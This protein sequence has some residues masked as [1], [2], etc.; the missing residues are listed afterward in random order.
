[1]RVVCVRARILVCV[2][3]FIVYCSPGGASARENRSLKNTLFWGTAKFCGFVIAK[4]IGAP[5]LCTGWEG[6]EGSVTQL[7]FHVWHRVHVGAPVCLSPALS[8]KKERLAAR[9]ISHAD[10]N[11]GIEHLAPQYSE[12]WLLFNFTVVTS[13]CVVLVE[14][15]LQLNI[16]RSTV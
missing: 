10:R 1:M 9:T 13:L 12:R 5:D 14:D 4:A 15:K 16:F 7:K 6:G 2:S 8:R 3:V 11:R